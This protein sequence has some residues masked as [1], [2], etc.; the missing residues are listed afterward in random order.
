[1]TF[2]VSPSYRV[3]AGMGHTTDTISDA[4]LKAALEVW[5]R[6]KDNIKDFAWLSLMRL[7]MALEF[8]EA[9]NDARPFDKPT[10]R[11][12]FPFVIAEVVR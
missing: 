10:L 4:S 7:A 2:N 6:D 3:V 12:L 8:I 1:M 9:K 11:A 5:A